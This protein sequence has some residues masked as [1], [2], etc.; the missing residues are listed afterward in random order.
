MPDDGVSGC[1]TSPALLLPPLR[2]RATVLQ[3]RLL[4][5]SSSFSARCLYPRSARCLSD[6]LNMLTLEAS[7]TTIMR[8]QA[9][10]SGSDPRLAAYLI[11]DAGCLM[12]MRCPYTTRR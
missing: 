7:P 4:H 6:G 10:P 8:S 1:R 9:Q 12:V 11:L 5:L 3:L 2:M